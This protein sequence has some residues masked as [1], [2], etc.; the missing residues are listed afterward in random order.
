MFEPRLTLIPEPDGQ[1]SLFAATRVPNECY[2]AAKAVRK[3]PAGVKIGAHAT[4]VRLS[5]HYKPSNEPGLP[6][7]L[8]HRLF[9]LDLAEG[10]VVTAFVMLD[11]MILGT[12]DIILDG[13]LASGALSTTAPFTEGLAAARPPLTPAL[14]QGVVVTASMHPGHF[15]KPSQQLVQLGVVDDTRAVIH[16]ANIQKGMKKLEYEI[17]TRNIKSGPAV[18]VAQSRD[19]VFAHAQ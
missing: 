19:S 3:A 17:D 8:H 1:F 15:T 16:R 10:D 4:A 12:A 18:T 6:R 5:L 13:S 9:D 11:G 2:V 14:C 7:E